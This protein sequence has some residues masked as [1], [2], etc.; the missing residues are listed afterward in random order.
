MSTLTQFFGGGGV[1]I[2]SMVDIPDQAP[3]V[4]EAGGQTFLRSGVSALGSTYPQ[5]PASIRG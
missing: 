4:Y 1:P 5:V 2:G 3:N